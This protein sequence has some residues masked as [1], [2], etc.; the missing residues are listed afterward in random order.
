MVRLKCV[1]AFACVACLLGFGAA[2]EPEKEKEKPMPE[3]PVEVA[4][5]QME[6]G[7]KFELTLVV[8]DTNENLQL[9]REA[10]VFDELAFSNCFSANGKGAFTATVRYAKTGDTFTLRT[11][12]PAEDLYLAHIYDLQ[13]K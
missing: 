2:A 12:G 7:A 3:S 1:I 13:T 5:K 11:A 9:T 6:D 8:A 10:G 4:T